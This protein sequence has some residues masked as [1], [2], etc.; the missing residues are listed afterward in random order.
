MKIVVLDM[1]DGD[2]KL[3]V[4]V[5]EKHRAKSYA[6]RRSDEGDYEYFL[7]DTQELFEDDDFEIKDWLWNH[8]DWN[9]VKQF[10]V[11]S[12]KVF[13]KTQFEDAF[14]NGDHHFETVETPLDYEGFAYKEAE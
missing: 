11:K 12:P 13:T 3:P 4:S 9:D 8:M 1:P 6:E 14:C 10:C 7:K 2:Y 5:I